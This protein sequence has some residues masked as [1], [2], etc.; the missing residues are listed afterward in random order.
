MEL[1]FE[2]SFG[3]IVGLT[4]CWWCELMGEFIGND[5]GV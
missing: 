3:L 4:Y 5:L 1:P 2:L